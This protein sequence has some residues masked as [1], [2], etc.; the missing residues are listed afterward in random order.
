MAR[1][2]FSY[3]TILNEEWSISTFDKLQ[4]EGWEIINIC[5]TP[6]RGFIIFSR[7]PI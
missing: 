5:G 3:I 6:A 2:V 4:D 1:Y 7:R